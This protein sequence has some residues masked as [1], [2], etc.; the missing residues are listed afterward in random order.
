MGRGEPRPGRDIGDSLKVKIGGARRGVWGHFA[1]N[2]KGDALDLVAYL[3][4]DGAKA[5][6]LKWGIGWLGLGGERS[7]ISHQP[8]AVNRQPS[9][10]SKESWPLTS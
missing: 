5:P 4:F 2:A 9:T 6:A 3:M 1:A 8:S 7:V 10:V